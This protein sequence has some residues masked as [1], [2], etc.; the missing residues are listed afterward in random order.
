[1]R[2]N[3][4]HTDTELSDV[5]RLFFG[6]DFPSVSLEYD[7]KTF[8]VELPEKRYEF[9]YADDI[10]GVIPPA[11]KIGRLS[12]IAVYDALCAFTGRD[13]A[14][15]ALTGVRPSKLFYECLRSGMDNAAA[16]DAMQKIYRVSGMRSSVL[17]EI[18]K[19]QKGKVEFSSEY[20]NL[21][22]HVPYCTTRCSYCSFVSA[23]IAKNRAQ[24]Q[25]YV[26]LLCDEI[27]R[28]KDLLR[29][30]GKKILSVYIGGGTP[31]A[32]DDDTFA[33]LLDAIGDL[34]CE[35]TCEAGRPDTVA[36][37][38]ADIMRSHGVTRVC[39]NP[40]TLNDKTLAA[41]GRSHS[42]DD[43]F[44]AY[45]TVRA[46]GFD[47]NCDLIAGLDGETLDDFVKSLDGV[48]A[49]R[50]QNITVHSLSKKNGSAI[51]YRSDENSDISKMLDHALTHVDGY[52]PYYLYR[53]KRQAGNLENI[54]FSLPECEC[55]NNITTMEET[56]GVMACGAGAISKIF[57][58]GNI[59]RFA[60]MRDVSLYISRYDEKLTAKLDCFR[61]A[62]A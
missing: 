59:S 47:V 49:L 3:D 58:N 25:Q 14:W 8:T 37:E 60:N 26:K 40:Q 28:S 43:F 31:S 32:L 39:V 9:E 56:V 51:R 41:I 10:Y 7:G 48:Y 13:M 30:C 57:E 44:R 22:V 15:G 5:A 21:Y 46:R 2:V 42:A 20:Y 27:M 33:E 29:E 19:A 52:R 38:K 4:I 12:K 36:S 54:G 17:D 50:P 1:M 62:F 53:Q 55:V 16:V 61:A 6:D 18:I 35:Y 34:G 45:D 24:S 11:H 23:P